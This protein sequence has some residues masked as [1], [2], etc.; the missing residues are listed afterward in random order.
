M[1]WTHA[2]KAW[3]V[4]VAALLRADVMLQALLKCSRAMKKTG[5][6]NNRYAVESA[7]L[8]NQNRMDEDMQRLCCSSMTMPAH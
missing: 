5:R 6:D 8:F 3:E 7:P 2:S 1:I 4:E